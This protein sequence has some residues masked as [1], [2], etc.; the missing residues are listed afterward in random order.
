MP[1]S[2]RPTSS[3]AALPRAKS[4]SSRDAE[5]ASLL[6]MAPAAHA[7]LFIPKMPLIGNAKHNRGGAA[8]CNRDAPLM[9]LPI[10]VV[11]LRRQ[12]GLHAG[13]VARFECCNDRGV[14]PHKGIQERFRQKPEHPRA[15]A[16]CQRPDTQCG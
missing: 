2:T 5:G 4:S 15:E 10:R 1:P 14:A 9:H 12:E 6:R 8:I 3:A 13:V 16:E 7:N 11:R